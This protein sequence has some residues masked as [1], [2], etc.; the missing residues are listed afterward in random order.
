[1]KTQLAA[2][3]MAE[4]GHPKRLAIY[5]RLVKAGSQ[6]LSVGEIGQALKMPGSTLSHHIKRLVSVGL[7]KQA[8]EK[9]VIRCTAVYQQLNALIVFLTDKC[10]Q[11][12]HC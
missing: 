12:N 2:Q 9:Q 10:C 6:G 8:P 4:L 3:C 11:G 5:R 1:M 7:V